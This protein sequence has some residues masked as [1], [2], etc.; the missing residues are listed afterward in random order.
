MYPFNFPFAK[1]F[2]RLGLPLSIM[3]IAIKDDEAGVYYAYSPN[4]KGLH[5]E[6][7]TLDEVLQNVKDVLPYLLEINEGETVEALTNNAP[8]LNLCTPLHA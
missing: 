6:G 1:F 5:V 2:G 7:D 8:R 4:I 3:I